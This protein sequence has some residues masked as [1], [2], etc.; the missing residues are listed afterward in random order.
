MQRPNKDK[1]MRIALPRSSRIR[2]IEDVR[3]SRYN[4]ALVSDRARLHGDSS[5]LEVT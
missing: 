4:C 3:N 5:N 2:S 1:Q